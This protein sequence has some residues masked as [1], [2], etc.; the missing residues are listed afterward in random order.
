LSKPQK[1]N[2]NHPKFDSR[3]TLVKKTKQVLELEKKL[4]KI[5]EEPKKEINFG[6]VKKLLFFWF[7]KKKY[8]FVFDAFI[9]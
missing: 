9:N 1:K 7:C 3:N 2:A 6:T 4:K 8:R 5:Q